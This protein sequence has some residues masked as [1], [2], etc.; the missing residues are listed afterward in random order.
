MTLAKLAFG[1][2]ITSLAVTNPAAADPSAKVTQRGNQ[3]CISS[4][5][6]PDHETGQFPNRGN[7]HRLQAQS[8]KVCVPANPQKGA[9]AQQ[10]QTVG[11]AT[12]GIIIRPGTADYYDARS[13]RGHSRNRAS[14]WNLEGMGA[15]E[16]LGLDHQNAHVDHRGIYH[17][18]GMPPAL[19]TPG[20]GTRMG[21]AADGFEIHHV[22]SARSSWQLKSGTRP[23]APGG[24]YDGTYNEDF[25]YRPGSGNLDECNG[26]VVN[27]QYY[28]FAT[29]TYPFFPRCLFGTRITR[30]R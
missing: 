12:N 30:I 16:T 8:I 5:G 24:R 2:L 14:G 22:A 23:S 1:L 21:W 9:R 7:P 15:R 18:H 20:Q 25:E 26:A 6:V 29:D 28:Y 13:P 3:L 10:V 19:D 17:Y 11:I 4:N 27:G